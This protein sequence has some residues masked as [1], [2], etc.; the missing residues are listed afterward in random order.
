MK[1]LIYQYWDTY[2]SNGI[3]VGV[4]ACIDNIKMYADRI[5]AEYLFELDPPHL[6]NLE[7]KAYY[8]AVNPIFREE[9]HEYDNV[10][11]LDS[12]VFAVDNIEENIF[13]Q[14]T[15]DIAMV[16][17]IFDPKLTIV[18]T[19]RRLGR[20]VYEAW[21][22]AVEPRYNIK[23]PRTRDGLLRAFNS[24]VVVYS[25]KGM[26]KAKESFI[27]FHDY[28]N[29]IMRRP[30]ERF[31]CADQHYINTS[32]WKAGLDVQL[33]DY[34]WNTQ[35]MFFNKHP[36]EILLDKNENTRFVHVQLRGMRWEQNAETLSKIVNLPVE[37]WGFGM[38][39]I[40]ERERSRIL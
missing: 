34:R 19:N 22:A 10:L 6:H 14:I 24:G 16:E 12:D 39:N 25:N 5:G 11:F 20:H 26:K 38:K 3:P 35:V 18:E 21:A 32:M 27:P 37:E 30:V 28:I 7:A 33:L 8:G 31:F 9:F 4:Q 17:E 1:N 15:G 23:L 29:L 36:K 13:D 40:I 2:E